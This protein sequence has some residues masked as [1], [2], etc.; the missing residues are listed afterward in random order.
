[1]RFWV[2]KEGRLRGSPVRSASMQSLSPFLVAIIRPASC[3]QG[4]LFGG[5][6][7]G[8]QEM[9][10]ST[11]V[12][13]DMIQIVQALI[14]IFIAAPA[15]IRAVYHIRVTSDETTEGAIVA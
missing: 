3:W 5:L 4:L 10:A 11:N 7:S 15:L 6:K 1:M 9:Q 13:V 12:P 14:I 2:S 8:A